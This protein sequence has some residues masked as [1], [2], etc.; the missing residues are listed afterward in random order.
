M[1]RLNALKLAC[2]IVIKKTHSH[3]QVFAKEG[4]PAGLGC[5]VKIAK[6]KNGG[7]S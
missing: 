4:L 7:C 6:N 2:L 3:C 5:Q 1:S